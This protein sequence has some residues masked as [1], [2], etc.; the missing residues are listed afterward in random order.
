MEVDHGHLLIGHTADISKLYAEYKDPITSA[1]TTPPPKLQYLQIVAT[2]DAAELR[3]AE[4]K[5]LVTS[6]PEQ[7]H[8]M[9]ADFRQN[10]KKFGEDQDT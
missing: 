10:M 1:Q 8:L 5:K 2:R 3:E 6:N 9:I 7:L 4:L